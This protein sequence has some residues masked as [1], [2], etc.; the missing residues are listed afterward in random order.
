MSETFDAA[1]EKVRE[2]LA[3]APPVEGSFKFEIADEGVILIRDGALSTE[4]GEADVTVRADMETF[5]Q[6][7]AG[8]LSPAAAFMTGKVDVDGDVSMAMRL[9]SLVG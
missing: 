7:F 6:M 3:D 8:E 1:V 9:S 4:D 5:R 2:K